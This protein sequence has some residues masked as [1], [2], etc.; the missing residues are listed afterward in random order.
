MKLN[1]YITYLTLYFPLSFVCLSVTFSHRSWHS[2]AQQ[3]VVEQRQLKD[4]ADIIISIQKLE[5]DK[6]MLV[7]AQHLDIMN[8]RGQPLALKIGSLNL[9]STETNSEYYIE[10]IE[11]IKKSI[12]THLENFQSLKCDYLKD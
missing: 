11:E 10:K 9:S 5:K 8:L 6:L 12:S 7:A 3:E 4:V 1:L 2:L